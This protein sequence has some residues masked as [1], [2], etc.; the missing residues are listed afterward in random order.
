M[1]FQF[2]SLQDGNW[3]DPTVWHA[4]YAIT[5][6]SSGSKRFTIAG[7][8]TAEFPAGGTMTVTDSLIGNN[9]NYTIVS[10]SFST[11][12]TITVNESVVGTAS[13][14]GNLHSTVLPVTGASYTSTTLIDH[15]INQDITISLGSMAF[16]FGSV[17]SGITFTN[18]TPTQTI[19]GTKSFRQTVTLVNIKIVSGAP[20]V[21]SGGT[22]NLVGGSCN[23][24]LTIQ[25]GSA[26]NTTR[27]TQTGTLS[28]ANSNVVSDSASTFGTVNFSAG[29]ATC[30]WTGGIVTAMSDI[31]QQNVITI[32]DAVITTLNLQSDSI[33]ITIT[34]CI[35]GTLNFTI[36][37]VTA[38]ATTVGTSIANIVM[39]GSVDV[40][41][42][43]STSGSTITNI[44]L[45]GE[46]SI[47]GN[48]TMTGTFLADH[49]T[50]VI[51]LGSDSDLI[52]YKSSSFDVSAATSITLHGTINI[53]RDIDF[54]NKV[55]AGS[56][57]TLNIVNSQAVISGMN[58]GGVTIDY[59]GSSGCQGIIGIGI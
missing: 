31:L 54:S 19:S 22:L 14:D 36:A 7:D 58:G 57:A 35:I 55:D 48:F 34:D 16:S 8:Q 28:V 3:S 9:G 37:S 56:D 12:T 29:G 33:T 15:N 59:T 38:A 51:V 40:C 46:C 26:L 11:Q 47:T 20:T 13:P 6:A 42:L 21:I 10:S 5:G 53:Y 44:D 30:F 49:S 23:Q 4:S 24:T 52:Q 2:K 45:N 32:N 43:T 39:D 27:F 17:N 41:T 1:S 50:P 25:T 18:L